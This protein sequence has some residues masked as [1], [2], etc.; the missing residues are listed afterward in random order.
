MPI[1]LI[2]SPLLTV[3]SLK[4]CWFVTS[5]AIFYCTFH[6]NCSFKPAN[7]MSPP[8]LWMIPLHMTEPKPFLMLSNFRMREMFS[9]FTLLSYSLVWSQWLCWFAALLHFL[10]LACGLLLLLAKMTYSLSAWAT[11]WAMPKV[12]M[13]FNFR[14]IDKGWLARH[15]S[16]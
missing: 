14:L 3:S 15:S 7:C 5:L 1:Y 10:Y 9:I 12:L 13:M 2:K 6:G 8:F 11:G 16:A 4:V